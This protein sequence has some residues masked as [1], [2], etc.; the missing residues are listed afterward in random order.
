[1]SWMTLLILEATKMVTSHVTIELLVKNRF[2]YNGLW[3]GFD[4]PVAYNCNLRSRSGLHVRKIVRNDISHLII[5]SLVKTWFFSK[6]S[7]AAILDFCRFFGKR[8]IGCMWNFRKAIYDYLGIIRPIF[9]SD[10]HIST[11]HSVNT[12]IFHELTA[13]IFNFL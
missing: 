3:S 12:S 4:L 13:A 11:P 8:D 7:L 6:Y 9:S 2:H 10:I 1:M 5:G